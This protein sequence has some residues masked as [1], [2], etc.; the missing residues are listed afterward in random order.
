MTDHNTDL[1]LRRAIEWFVLLKDDKATI[2][3][4]RAFERWLAENEIHQSAFQRAEQ[5]W[6][7]FDAVKPSYEK[8][9]D[10]KRVSRRHVV[11]GGLAVFVAA[12]SIYMLTRPGL[13]ADYKTDVAERREFSLPDGSTV[14]LGS[15]SAMSLDFS[16]DIR[17]LQLH[18][19]QAFFSVAPDADRSFIVE[20]A[21]GSIRA[22]GTKFDVKIE[23]QLVRVSV[24]EHSV[25]LRIDNTDVSPVVIEQDWQ[26]SY[27]P[28]G[29]EPPKR[30]DA[31]AI[32]AWRQD[33]IVFKD[34]PLHQVLAELERYRRGRILLMDDAAANI[35]VTAVFDTKRA[36]DALHVIADTLPISV[37]NAD[38]YVAMVYS[39]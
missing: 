12:P 2:A 3:D 33:R 36:G 35:P 21:G 10:A 29:I 18:G 26:V 22:L 13:F 8:F 7:R 17:R 38:G 11:I 1:A 27:G 9:R 23:P 28:S 31:G 20:A 14:E 6:D 15:H 32:E 25:E 16:P 34:V 39:R 19:G 5:L 4:R 24:L 30:L 37:I